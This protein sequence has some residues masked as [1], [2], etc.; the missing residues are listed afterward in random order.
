MGEYQG[1]SVYFPDFDTWTTFITES[2]MHS[3]HLM[4]V[5]QARYSMGMK[6]VSSTQY[7]LEDM[8]A[9]VKV[10]EE[11][12]NDKNPVLT[13]SNG[14]NRESTDITDTDGLRKRNVN[15]EKSDGDEKSH[16]EDVPAEKPSPK[17]DPIKWFGVLVPQALRDSQ[18]KFR[19]AAE[20]SCELAMLKVRC[21]AQRAGFRTKLENKESIIKG[22]ANMSFSG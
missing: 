3:K 22:F 19:R 11:F 17:K 21:D 12:D 4:H 10:D 5:F 6:W 18:A 13:I 7:P 15:D 2:K 16:V 20:L 9:S 8:T 14:E 1:F